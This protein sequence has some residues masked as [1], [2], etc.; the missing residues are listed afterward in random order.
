MSIYTIAFVSEGH[1][2]GHGL[3]NYKFIKGVVMKFLETIATL[4]IADSLVNND[5]SKRQ[6][7]HSRKFRKYHGKSKKKSTSI[8]DV[9]RFFK[10]NPWITKL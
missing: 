2:F 4:V 7:H 6:H 5:A 9:I 3:L 8:Y 10:D 1:D